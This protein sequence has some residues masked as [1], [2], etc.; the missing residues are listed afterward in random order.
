VFFCCTLLASGCTLLA[1]YNAGNFGALLLWR[2]L[3]GFFLA[4][5]YPVGMK[6]ASM[7]FPRGL[8]TALGWLLAA[9]VLGWWGDALLLGERA[10]L[11]LAGLAAFLWS[12]LCFALAFVAH[13]VSLP[14]LVTAGLAAAGVGWVVLRWLW[15]HVPRGMKPAVTVYVVV[16]LLMCAC[17]ASHS[18]G[19]GHWQVLAGAILFAASD[20]AVARDRFVAKGFV[21]KL[22]GLPTYYVAQLV[23]AWTL[24]FHLRPNA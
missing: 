10:P 12:H 22:W 24:V 19:S 11:F 2:V 18:A 1:M 23:L 3:T 14:T 9:L 16:I 17:A 5:I 6:L 13:G 15:P 21:N 20:L 7:W 4:G 8:G